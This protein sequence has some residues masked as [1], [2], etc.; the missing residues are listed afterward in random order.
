M[1]EPLGYDGQSEYVRLVEGDAGDDAWPH[2]LELPGLRSAGILLRQIHDATTDW[3]PPLDAEWSVPPTSRI[4]CHGD[5][6]PANFAWRNGRVIGLFDWDAA[7]PATRLSDVAY[8]LLW[9]TPI[10][11]DDGELRRRGFVAVPD[12]RARAEALLEGY[13]WDQPIDIIDSAVSR[14]V[15][16]IDE[17][18]FLG[19]GGHEPQASWVAGGWPARWRAGLDEL[20][21]V[22]LDSAHE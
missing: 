2:Q 17:V 19:S 16:A 11:A 22:T 4:V 15:Q 21:G 3:Q 5:P 12:R 9:F 10:N 1:P 7:R 13:G 20:R 6:Q 18:D 14:H 8:A